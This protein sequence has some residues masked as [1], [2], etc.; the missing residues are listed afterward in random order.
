M[1][2]Y[3]KLIFRFWNGETGKAIRRHG[4]QV[5]VVALYL[6]SSPSSNMIGL[7]YLP[8]PILCH[9]VG[10]SL[11]A[12]QHALHAL[13]EV[14]FAFYDASTEHIW[15]PN[16]ARFQ[17]GEHLKPG[18]KQIVAVI[19]ALNHVKNSPFVGDFLKRYQDIF[20]LEM[21]N[22]PEAPSEPLRRPFDGP[23]KPGAGAG[24]GAE[25]GIEAEP[26][27][28][29]P[30]GGF[31]EFFN[32]YPR[33]NAKRLGRS[34]A[35]KKYSLLNAED[36]TLLLTAV[37]NYASSEMVQKGIGIKDA[38]RWLHDDNGEEEWRQWLTPEEKQMENSN[39]KTWQRHSGF[40]GKDYTAGA[41]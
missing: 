9:E 1:R 2:D 8:I 39:G 26:R 31:D 24:A 10:C 32:L 5:Q 14:G 30:T 28:V 20:H 13:A 12:A 36:R 41:F 22:L 21:T 35:L 37:R 25:A 29:S 6:V 7:Y 23:S 3:S 34:E 16:M 11:Q 4:P 38:H 18:D 17:I 27:D 15:V 40:A 19:K 33:R